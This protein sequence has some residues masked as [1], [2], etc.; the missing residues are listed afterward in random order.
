[1]LIK[2]RYFLLSLPLLLSFAFLRNTNTDNN[3]V[4]PNLPLIRKQL[5]IALDSKQT[6]D[7]LFDQLAMIKGR[8]ALITGYMGALQ[9]LKAKHAWNP[10]FK[11]KHLSDCEKT[12][13]EAVTRDP[14]NIEIRFMRFSI[15]HNV[16]SILGY[17][18]N[19]VADREQ[20]IKQIDLKYYAQADLTL[21]KTIINFLLNSKRCTPAEQIDLKKHLA[22]L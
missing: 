1:M 11:I 2:F 10:Y 5:I 20:I 7:S 3:P 4:A 22:A 14:T 12:F 8:S 15:E 17:D 19:L 9:A 18:E 13:K 6:T 21:V 16:P